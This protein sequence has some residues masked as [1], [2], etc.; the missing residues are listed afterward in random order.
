MAQLLPKVSYIMPTLN[1]GT[2]LENSLGSIVRQTYPRDR[3][4]IILA[5]AMSKGST[6]EIA[7]RNGATVVDDHG[8]DME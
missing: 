2:L 6:R 8:R 5:D 7:A 4:E 3:Y 1:A